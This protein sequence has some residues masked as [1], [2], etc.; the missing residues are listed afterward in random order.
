MVFFLYNASM[1]RLLAF[2]LGK[3]LDREFLLSPQ[4]SFTLGRDVEADLQAD[5]D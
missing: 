1:F 3:R 4:K 2:Y 5:W